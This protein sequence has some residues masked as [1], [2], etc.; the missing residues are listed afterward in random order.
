L[1]RRAGF[2][3]LSAALRY[4]VCLIAL[5]GLSAQVGSSE[6]CWMSASRIQIPPIAGIDG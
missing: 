6:C 3:E 4:G 5:A 2:A 1:A